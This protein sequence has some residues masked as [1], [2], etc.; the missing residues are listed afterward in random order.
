MNKP[1]WGRWGA[2]ALPLLLLGL[3][4]CGGSDVEL[5]SLDC[6]PGAGITPYC[7]F[8]N[9]ED[10]APADDWLIISEMEGPQDGGP[11]H[12]M[13][14]AWHPETQLR[15]N[16]WPAEDHDEH[17]GS[18]ECT[19][20]ETINAHGLDVRPGDRR[21]RY[22]LAAINHRETRDTIEF[23]EVDVR[24]DEPEA[25]YQ[26]CINVP[27]TDFVNDVV[28]LG[29]DGD[30]AATR[31]F[32]FGSSAFGLIFSGLLLAQDTGY[33]L[34]WRPGEGWSELPGTDGIQP[35]GITADPT[36]E[37]IYVN[38][39]W[40]RR[41][42]RYRVDGGE[43]Q[44]QLVF[45]E[46]DNL[47]N[48]TWAPDGTLLIASHPGGVE[49][50]VSCATVVGRNCLWTSRID[51]VD[52]ETMQLLGR[53]EHTGEPFGLATVA[54]QIGDSIW[55]GSFRGDRIARISAEELASR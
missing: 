47:D 1:F 44:E 51:R 35:N 23:F 14:V 39:Y 11:E 42:H 15:R 7:G 26:G 30:L 49:A 8:E 13:L 5:A 36:G 19:R 53:W 45:S 41:T 37:Y 31:M 55:L 24:G 16:L 2:P 25:L 9:P 21:K 27:P 52:P 50:F 54:T 32:E 40:E 33:V 48:I 17:I 10:I 12:G 18:A 20:P 22:R 34:L 6:A 3:A 46:D 29:E 4:G 43:E 28:F 38:Y